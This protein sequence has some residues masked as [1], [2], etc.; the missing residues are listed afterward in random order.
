MTRARSSGRTLTHRRP[1]NEWG[2]IDCQGFRALSPQTF[3]ARC[4]SAADDERQQDADQGNKGDG[5]RFDQLADCID[6]SLVLVGHLVEVSDPA[7]K[8]DAWERPVHVG[9]SWLDALMG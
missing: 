1:G 2:N 8:P 3:R 4:R 5:E 7:S 6:Q 9:R